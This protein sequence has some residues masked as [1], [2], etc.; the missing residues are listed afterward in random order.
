MSLEQL[1][2]SISDLT[3]EYNNTEKFS[4]ALLAKKADQLLIQYPHDATLVS[5]G[6]I[7]RRVQD[8]KAFIT[9]KDLVTLYND[10]FT[11]NTKFA[12]L[13]SDELNLK[14]KAETIKVACE[15][16]PE[17]QITPNVDPL[18]AETIKEVFAGRAPRAYTKEIAKKAEDRVELLLEN[19]DLKPASVK[20]IDGDESVVLVQASY[21]TPKGLVSVILPFEVVGSN[22]RDMEFFI[23]ASGVSDLDRNT[24]KES[25]TVNAGKKILFSTKSIIASLK[26]GS[27]K[28]TSTE[29]FVAARNLAKTKKHD[30]LLGT[31]I[32]GV[33]LESK[34]RADIEVKKH[35][36]EDLLNQVFN[37]PAGNAEIRFGVPTVRIA[38]DKLLTTLEKS[39]CN[40]KSIKIAKASESSISFAV[41]LDGQVAFTVPVK[42]SSGKVVDPKVFILNGVVHEITPSNIRSIYASNEKDYKA[43][44][45]ASPLFELRASDLI[46]TVRDAMS[47]SN[48][49]KAE[50]ALNVLSK[51]NDEKAY[52]NAFDVYRAGLL[53][54]K[55][56]EEVAC[57]EKQHKTAS[58]KYPICSHT[59]LPIN[60]VYKDQ[61][62]MCRPLY[63]RGMEESKSGG[64]Y[65]TQRIFQ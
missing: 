51:M 21:D 52:K 34:P 47:E 23:N 56:Q 39:S 15:I 12:S 32:L 24:L 20:A 63:R 19:I 53:P 7:L 29:L 5:V 25:I 42:I 8:K 54:P 16:K 14:K 36:S 9:R 11:N 17:I 44:A 26:E 6:H 30:M 37:T 4:T 2:K 33:K 31:P 58:S 22:V 41:S 3:A 48:I 55:P 13:F 10:H 28:I 49:E 1:R 62:G 57:C 45:V 50:D 61:H 46:D 65:I 18:F 35:A 59:G 27:G 40:V 64:M 60:Q 43:A 38:K